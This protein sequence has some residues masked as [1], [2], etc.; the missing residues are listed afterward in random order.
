MDMGFAGYNNWDSTADFCADLGYI[1][2][3]AASLPYYELIWTFTVPAC[4]YIRVSG[5]ISY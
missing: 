3:N 2:Y 5:G 4:T 1:S